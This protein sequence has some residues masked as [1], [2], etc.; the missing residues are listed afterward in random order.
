MPRPSDLRPGSVSL[1]WTLLPIHR[2]S[3]MGHFSQSLGPSES[4]RMEPSV[5]PRQLYADR[6]AGG[7]AGRGHLLGERVGRFLVVSTPPWGYPSHLP[8][9]TMSCPTTPASWTAPQPWLASRRQCPRHRE[10]PGPMAPTGL[11]SPQ[12]CVFP[13]CSHFPPSAK[14]ENIFKRR[15]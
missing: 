2:E 7:W 14:E 13:F 5:P 12:A 15:K 11:P 6:R 8:P 9:S 1:P 3:L 10:P 4:L